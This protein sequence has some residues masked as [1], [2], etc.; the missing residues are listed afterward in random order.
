MRALLDTHT[1]L[2]WF[3]DRPELSARARAVI[4]EPSNEILVSAASGWEISTKHRIGK[5]Q[6]VEPLLEDMGGWVAQARLTDLPVEIPHAQKAGSWSHDHRDPFD[7]M[8]AAQ[9]MLE[10]V[11]LVTRDPVFE[12]FGILLIW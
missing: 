8:L 10:G 7:R 1:L 3:F 2:W 5:L 12:S 4:A 11:P 9:A 6:G